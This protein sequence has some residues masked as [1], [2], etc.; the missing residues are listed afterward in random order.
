ME[1]YSNTDISKDN[2]NFDSISEIANNVSIDNRKNTSFYSQND[3]IPE[4]RSSSKK[5]DIEAIKMLPIYIDRVNQNI[6]ILESII[7]DSKENSRV[8]NNNSTSSSN[9]KTPS[10]HPVLIPTNSQKVINKPDFAVI[11]ER[12]EDIVSRTSCL[13]D[14]QKGFKAAVNKVVMKK[15]K[16]TDIKTNY[17]TISSKNTLICN[18]PRTKPTIKR[19]SISGINPSIDVKKLKNSGENLKQKSVREVEPMLSTIQNTINNISITMNNINSAKASGKLNNNLDKSKKLIKK[20]TSGLSTYINNIT[21]LKKPESAGLKKTI[22]LEK[23]KTVIPSTSISM[24][25]MQKKKP[26]LASKTVIQSKLKKPVTQTKLKDVSK[27]SPGFYVKK[28]NCICNCERKANII[29]PDTKETA[30]LMY[31]LNDYIINTQGGDLNSTNLLKNFRTFLDNEDDNKIINTDNSI[32]IL[33]N[34]RT[35]LLKRNIYLN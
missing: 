3:G 35:H 4:H 10:P 5:V 2:I 32:V 18:S 14:T 1:G 24:Q 13:N 8:D 19:L 17:N 16:M 22:L 9:N 28:C 21:N 34:L 33:Y 11:E 31:I 23:K 7:K 15:L 20:P 6:K 25:L 29:K 30:E 27:S 12:D 26:I